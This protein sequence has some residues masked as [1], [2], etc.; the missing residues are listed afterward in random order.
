MFPKHTFI[1]QKQRVQYTYLNPEL[2][3]YRDNASETEGNN[4][5]YGVV[6]PDIAIESVDG[7]FEDLF[8][9]NSQPE[10]VKL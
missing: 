1:L 5:G 7:V 3:E 4:D 2:V 6:D 8:D 9:E 10:T